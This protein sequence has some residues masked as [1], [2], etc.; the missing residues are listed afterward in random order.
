M[1]LEDRMLFFLE[2]ING[3]LKSRRGR[4]FTLNVALPIREFLRQARKES[5]AD[6]ADAPQHG[7]W[8]TRESDAER[9]SSMPHCHFDAF[10]S[11]RQLLH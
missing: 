3:R 10:H 2:G 5:K 6:R 9:M 1:Q 8:V 11:V 7:E 4:A